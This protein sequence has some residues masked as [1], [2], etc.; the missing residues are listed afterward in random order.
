MRGKVPTAVLDDLL[1]YLLMVLRL[2]SY[3]IGPC[4]EAAAELL[5]APIYEYVLGLIVTCL[6]MLSRFEV[7]KIDEAGQ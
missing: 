1:Q 7:S 6:A 2:F 3:E 5:I 4:L